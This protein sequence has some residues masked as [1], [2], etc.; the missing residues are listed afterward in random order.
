MVWWIIL[1]ILF[2][3]LIIFLLTGFPVA[4]SFMLLN[5]IGVLWFWGGSAGFRQLVL[6]IDNSLTSFTLVPIVLFV[7]MGEIMMHSGIGLKCMDVLD[8]WMGRFPGR[9]ALLS[10]AAGTLF[11]ALSG[12][13]MASTAMLGSVLTKKMEDKGYERKM[14]MGPLMASGGIAIL[15]PPSALAVFLASVG[16]IS[17]S[18]L[19][20]A[21]VVPG[22][23][24]A[25]MYTIYIVLTCIFKP[26]TAPTYE[27][28]KISLK[29]KFILLLKYVVPVFLI[30][31]LVIGTMIL[32][33]ATPSESAALG[34]LGAFAVSLFYK[35]GVTRQMIKN[36]FKGTIKVSL[37]LLMIIAGANAFSQILSFSGASRGL[38]AF[39]SQLEVPNIVIIIAMQLIIFLLGC[40]IEPGAI[41]MITVPIFM[42][43]VKTIGANPV[44][45]AAIALINLQVGFM[46]PP[47]GMLLFTMKGVA[48]KSATMGEIYQ[49][50]IPFILICVLLIVL[51]FVLPDIA[52]ILP[53]LL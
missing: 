50:A 30:I 29:I 51:L 32:G 42:T 11:S 4:F 20:M 1:I 17:V 27:V 14:A 41:I 44:W 46:T 6:G 31:F 48:P 52:L 47:F 28:E 37:M 13:A 45:F 7:L 26:G 10:V 25:V 21:G 15:I 19:L 35:D 5:V 23:V 24:L 34:A 49:S 8:K 16:Q 40:F 36:T 18:R 22:L 33:I 12:S 53:G 3:S 38:V 39:I 2:V 43:I 9:L